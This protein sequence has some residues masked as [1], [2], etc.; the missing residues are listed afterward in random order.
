MI[1]CL[2]ILLG[3]RC[4]GA[5]RV[6]G[7]S[8]FGALENKIRPVQGVHA[9]VYPSLLTHILCTSPILTYRPT[10]QNIL[11]GNLNSAHA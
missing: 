5:I 2:Q 4:H 9:I 7:Y 11:G 8:T 6:F 3:L 10:I 1:G